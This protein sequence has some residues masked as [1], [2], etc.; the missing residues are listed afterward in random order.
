MPESIMARDDRQDGE[1][2][3][4]RESLQDIMAKPAAPRFVMGGIAEVMEGSA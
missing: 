2:W 1:Q 3:D 4:R